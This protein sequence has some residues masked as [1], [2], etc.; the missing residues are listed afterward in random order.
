MIFPAP[1]PRAKIYSALLFACVF[2]ITTGIFPARDELPRGTWVERQSGLILEIKPKNTIVLFG[3]NN[4]T[5]FEV[6]FTPEIFVRDE[7]WMSIKSI[8]EKPH[9]I[10]ISEKEAREKKTT[11]RSKAG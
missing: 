1:I 8:Q 7:Y 9:E 6:V 10:K 11:C 3:S 4:S 2:G 5:E